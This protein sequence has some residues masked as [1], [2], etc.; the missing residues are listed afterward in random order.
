MTNTMVHTADRETELRNQLAAEGVDS[1]DTLV[2]RLAATVSPFSSEDEDDLAAVE[3]AQ[4]PSVTAQPPKPH[5]PPQTAWFLDGDRHDAEVITELNGTALYSAV[6]SDAH[7]EPALHSFTSLEGL[8]SHLRAGDG[9]IGTSNPDSL[10]PISRY[11]E[12]INQ[13]GDL[14]QNNPGRA[15]HDLTQVRHGFLGL[16]NWND[17]ISS[18]DWCRW[19]ISLYEN[20]SYGGSQLYLRAGRTYNN[21]VDFGWNDRASAVVNWG[22][23][24]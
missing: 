7:G 18:V 12:D 15:W 4:S 17:L 8:R 6:G 22:Q 19:D 14:L 16:G 20:I 1:L 10:S 3:S 5:T 23:R 2:R 9:D 11:F 21:V 24:F 13:G